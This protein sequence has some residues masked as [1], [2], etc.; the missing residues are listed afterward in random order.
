MIISEVLLS[1]VNVHI[2]LLA[3]TQAKHEQAQAIYADPGPAHQAA[4]GG[5]AACCFADGGC[6][7]LFPTD[8][9]A[10][11]GTS[12]DPGSTC[13]PNCC[14][15]PFTAGNTCGGGTIHVLDTAGT[16]LPITINVSGD[17]SLATNGTCSESG[18][19]CRTYQQDGED[20]PKYE[21][22]IASDDCVIAAQDQGHW[23]S[24]TITA[25]SDVEISY[26]CTDPESPASP[27]FRWI[28]IVDDCDECAFTFRD[29]DA[30][31]LFDCNDG[32]PADV[33]TELPSGTYHNAVFSERYCEN[34][35]N[36]VACVEDIDCLPGE[37]PCITQTGPYDLKITAQVLPEVACCLGVD[38]I[39]NFDALQCLEQGGTIVAEC[40]PP[41]A[42]VCGAGACCLPN[43]E[44]VDTGGIG[45]SP[46]D[47]ELEL[48]GI[49]LPGEVCDD[50]PCPVCPIENDEN[51][52]GATGN[53]IVPIDRALDGT[54]IA[55]NWA[56]DFMPLATGALDRVCW[57]PAYFNPDLGIE[58]SAPGTTPPDDWELTIY[59][60]AGSA[61]GAVVL[62]TQT[63][64]PDAQ[65]S[66]GPTSRLWLYSAPVDPA[67]ML[68]GSDCYWI[69]ITGLGEGEFGCRVYWALSGDGNDYCF[70]EEGFVTG[71]EGGSDLSFCVSM[72]MTSIGCD[73]P[74]G[75]CCTANG[76]CA[77]N[78]FLPDCAAADGI[79]HPGQSCQPGLCPEAECPSECV[80]AVNLNDPADEGDC[81]NGLPCS[82]AFDTTFCD[83]SFEN[84]SMCTVTPGGNPQTSQIGADEWYIYT[85]GSNEEGIVTISTC[86]GG[87][88]DSVIA[89]YRDIC[90]LDPANDH[91][92]CGDDTCS[93]GA[94]MS[95]VSFSACPNTSY[96]IR[97]GGWQDDTGSGTMQLSLAPQS[98]GCNTP[99]PPLADNRFDISGTVKPCSTDEDCEA[100][101]TG[102]DPNTVCRDTTGD[103]APNACYV[104]RN[105]YLSIKPNEGLNDE[106]YAYR[107]SLE[108]DGAGSAVLGFVSDPERIETNASGLNIFYLSRIFDD[109]HYAN[110]QD[111][112]RDN[113][114]YVSIG[115]C[116]VA[117]N[118]KYR[119]QSIAQGADT[120]D[121]GSYSSALML[122]TVEHWGD[123]TGGGN[124]GDPPNGAAGTLVDVFAQIKGFQNTNNEPRDWLDLDPEVPDLILSLSDAFI[125]ILAFQGN[126]YPY[127]APLDCP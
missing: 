97:M 46:Q 71:F 123:V 67:P 47:C 23:E 44:C 45:P 5:A 113:G 77:E 28:V 1:L 111:C 85:T 30:D 27:G 21:I 96:Y 64:I 99:P 15:Q 29:P 80:E 89:V 116:E 84:I 34:S 54:G 119:I 79:W 35:A 68:I 50:G 25:N 40:L 7:N 8:C 114:G 62:P 55:H 24:F 74:F 122:P 65:V 20:C 117:P 94:G 115:D 39:D 16:T 56:D 41:P 76:A 78:V 72:E 126:E 87:N 13:D 82:R 75:A 98:I 125:G 26:C 22:C 100:G 10:A 86:E 33:F 52:Q 69:K 19:P 58:C 88:Y 101:E 73:T 18:E 37:G 38:C 51:C 118:Y 32:Q 6:Q 57:W 61:P 36:A 14:N 93:V 43:G 11:G 112:C 12:G 83:P 109:P 124:P 120:T 91:I 48:Y 110:W 66:L 60:D 104:M 127:S 42:D 63:I 4:A 81:D 2:I 53:F 92:A 59:A 121:E 49:Y 3:P 95:E 105:R 17:S 106:P 90:P 9:T 103:G 31:P 70:N 107:V 108:T 102:P